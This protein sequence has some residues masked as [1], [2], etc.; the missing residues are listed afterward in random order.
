[1]L[2]QKNLLA[3]KYTLVRN[4]DIKKILFE[5]FGLTLRMNVKNAEHQSGIG[6]KLTLHL[7]SY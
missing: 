2:R 5:Y 7:R 3:G 6:K 1:M 4:E